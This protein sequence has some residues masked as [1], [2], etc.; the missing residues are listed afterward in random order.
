MYV[1]APLK[2]TCAPFLEHSFCDCEEEIQTHMELV[3][4]VAD[5]EGLRHAEL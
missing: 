4:R 3:M 1:G 2:Q 5:L